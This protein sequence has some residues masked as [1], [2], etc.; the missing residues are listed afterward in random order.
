MS[1]VSDPRESSALAETVISSNPRV[2]FVQTLRDLYE[3][4]ELFVAFVS[5]DIRVRYRQTA[6]GVVWVILQPLATGVI[7]AALFG[8]ITGR[9]DGMETL[10]FFLAGL[11]PWTAF[12]N[13]VQMAANSM[14]VNANLVSKV[15]FPRMVVPG[16]HVVG[17]LLDFLISF[18]VL[19]IAAIVAGK[20]HPLLLAAMPPLVLLQFMAAWG[21]GL[22][23]S[24]LNAQYRDVKYA[25]PFLLQTGMFLTVL[26]PLAKWGDVHHALHTALSLNPMAAVVETYRAIL[27]GNAIDFLLLAE[28]FVVSL[29][30]LAAGLRFF[31]LRE[32]KIVDIL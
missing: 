8:V 5:R 29:L 22:F 6:L 25:I 9:F 30:L 24:A 19:V 13:G 16:A 17:S 31:T 11:V 14:E 12:Q 27:A 21:L 10:L 15:Y 1:I 4:R 3:Y 23:F 28:G 7:F 32:R 18:T 2:R 20:F 26:V